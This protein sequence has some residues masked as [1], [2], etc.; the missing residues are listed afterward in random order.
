ML[1]GELEPPHHDLG[2]EGVELVARQRVDRELTVGELKL[3]V[4]NKR[5]VVKTGGVSPVVVVGGLLI[6]ATVGWMLLRQQQSA[7]VAA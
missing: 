4:T 6:L 1:I 2:G 5:D 3:R 7:G